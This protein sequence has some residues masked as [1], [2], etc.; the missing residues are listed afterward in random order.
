MSSPG[1]GSL[2]TFT[3]AAKAC[4]TGKQSYVRWMT[5]LHSH[6]PLQCPSPLNLSHP[7]CPSFNLPS[8]TST[9]SRTGSPN[10]VYLP[11]PTYFRLLPYF[12]ITLHFI[13]FPIPPFLI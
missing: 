9:S 1:E 11:H 10:S 13:S 7:G 4:G 2:V 5:W 6:R 8:D 12:P 3:Q